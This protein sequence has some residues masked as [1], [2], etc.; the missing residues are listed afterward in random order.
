M[1]FS[2]ADALLEISLVVE[3]GVFATGAVEFSG[4]EF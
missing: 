3:E 2:E 1:E 4:V